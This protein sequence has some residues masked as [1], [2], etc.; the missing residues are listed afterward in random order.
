MFHNMNHSLSPWKDALEG[1]RN[2]TQVTS[3][4]KAS[5]VIVAYGPEAGNI[6]KILE[7]V[8]N[9]KKAS[10]E[11]NDD[12]LPRSLS[13]ALQLSSKSVSLLSVGYR[14][15]KLRNLERSEGEGKFWNLLKMLYSITNF[16]IIN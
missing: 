14:F 15:L 7:I 3:S 2:E 4:H 9:N 6:P 12:V 16:Q 13:R 11:I 8:S 10:Y 1:I 5:N